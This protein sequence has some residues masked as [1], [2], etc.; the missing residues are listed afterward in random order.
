MIASFEGRFNIDQVIY[1]LKKDWPDKTFDC[2][3]VA[4]AIQKAKIKASSFH[5][6]EAPEFFQILQGKAC[7]DKDWFVATKLDKK[8]QLQRIFWMSPSQRSLYH[9]YH[10]VVLNDNTYKTNQF[11]MPLNVLVIVN[12]DGKSHLVGC[13]LVSGETTQDYEWILQQLLEANDNLPPHVILVDEDPAMEAACANII[14]STILLNCIWHLGHQ[15]LNKNLHGALGQDWEEFASC[16]WRAWNA[17][18][19]SEFEHRWLKEV[20]VFGVSKPKVQGYLER[21]YEHCEHWAWSWVGMRFT[22]GMQSTQWIESVNA[23]I[24]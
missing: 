14:G 7:E 8:G 21:I 23:I 9:C 19:E 16:F 24:K 2:W 18:T 20:A 5:I 10:D 22:A 15:N 12:N 17:I 1:L 11:N 13:S 6:S 4:N 3:T